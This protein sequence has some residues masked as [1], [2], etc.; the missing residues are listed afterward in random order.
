MCVA[1]SILKLSCSHKILAPSFSQLQN[2]KL[3]SFVSDYIMLENHSF[4]KGNN[5]SSQILPCLFPSLAVWLHIQSSL[6]YTRPYTSFYTWINITSVFWQLQSQSE[7]STWG[8]AYQHDGLHKHQ[9]VL[10]PLS[11]RCTERGDKFTVVS[12]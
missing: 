3:A 12:Q 8:K 4:F 2:N 10:S 9:P 1:F 11:T 7:V 5:F 6:K